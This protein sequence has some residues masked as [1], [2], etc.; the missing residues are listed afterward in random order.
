MLL[1]S[2]VRRASSSHDTSYGRVV[3]TAYG[4]YSGA[5]KAT[6]RRASVFTIHPPDV[7]VLYG[8]AGANEVRES[9][10]CSGSLVSAERRENALA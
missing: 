6:K 1:W 10:A 8:H 3:P 9:T 5:A 2:P 4:R 7:Y